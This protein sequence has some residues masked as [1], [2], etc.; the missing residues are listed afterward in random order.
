MNKNS[1]DTI[2]R[3]VDAAV[4]HFS[5]KGYYGA[6]IDEIAKEAGVNKATLYY[7]IGDKD[8]LYGAV[9][10]RVLGG[11]AAQVADSIKEATT[12][13]E[14]IRAFIG[15]LAKN[16]GDNEHAAPLLLR[17]I[18]AG[19]ASLPDQVMLQMVRIFGALFCILDEAIAYGRFR[20]VNPL[21]MHLMILGGVTAYAAGAGLRDR[22]GSLGGEEFPLDPNVSAEEAGSQIADLIAYSLEK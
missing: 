10:E 6:R 19:G 5:Q 13:S 12:D 9:V 7:H 18:A 20:K 16:I 21:V 14:R 15:T 4:M 22:I 1:L 2:N 8:A 11:I 3:I 17:E